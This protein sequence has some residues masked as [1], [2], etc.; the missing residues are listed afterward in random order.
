MDLLESL[1]I[2][3]V[4]QITNLPGTQ[5][6]WQQE[7][8]ANRHQNQAKSCQEQRGPVRTFKATPQSFKLSGLQEALTEGGISQAGAPDRSWTATMS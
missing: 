5:I 4:F 1:L 8:G 6:C 7:I 2:R 3:P